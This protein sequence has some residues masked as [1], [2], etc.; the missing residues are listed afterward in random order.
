[1]LWGPCQQV[2]CS[3]STFRAARGDTFLLWSGK[4]IADVTFSVA[5]FNFGSRFRSW[6]GHA[7]R[8]ALHVLECSSAQVA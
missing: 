3:S 1:M 6:A 2:C 8:F 4:I 7:L 5:I